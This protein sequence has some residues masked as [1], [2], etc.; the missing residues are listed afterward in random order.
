MTS[1]IPQSIQTTSGGKQSSQV[2]LTYFSSRVPTQYDING[3]NVGQRWIILGDDLTATITGA[4]QAN[5]CVITAIN[6]FSVGQLVTISSVA[7][8][9]ELNGN[10]YQILSADGNSFVIDVDSSS[11]TAY[12]SGGTATVKTV[13]EYILDGFTASNG[14]VTANWIL[15]NGSSGGAA[16]SGAVDTLTG[17]NSSVVVSS[18]T[19]GNINIVGTSQRSS[20]QGATTDGGGIYITGNDSTH[21]LT[22]T[23]E[24][25][26]SGNTFLGVDAGNNSITVLQAIQNVGVGERSLQD[27]TTGGYNTSV[28]FDSLTSL[29]SG[30]LNCAFGIDA[31]A[32]VTTASRNTAFGAF[33]L[34]TALGASNTAIGAETFLNLTSG[35]TNIGIGYQSGNSYTGAESSNVLIANLGTL[36]ENNT[37]HIG[38]FGTGSGQQNVTKLHGGTVTADSGDINA[39][40]AQ[41][42]G[43]VQIS[44]TNTSTTASSSARINVTTTSASNGDS[45]FLCNIT[46]VAAG[47]FEFGAQRSSGNFVI[48]GNVTNG[49]GNLMDGTTGLS[50]TSGGI[51]NYPLQPAFLV[52]LTTDATN[53]TGNGAGYSLGTGG[54]GAV[55]T[56]FDK[57]TNITTPAGVTTFTAPVAGRYYFH[58]RY[59]VNNIDAGM[60][61]GSCTIVTTPR[62]FQGG[63]INPGAC[64]DVNNQLGVFQCSAFIELSAGNTVTTQIALSGGGGDTA[65]INSDATN[66]ETYFEGWLVT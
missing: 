46:N 29:T 51:L 42:G 54:G 22:A 10:Q 65:G 66:P 1:Q 45:Y 23:Y 40:R 11:F 64:R 35:S 21:T 32:D 4:S 3:W 53:V 41:A 37:I 44:A 61:G 6:G 13:Q 18:D 52:I 9:T 56:I 20:A 59:S 30:S 57:G 39:S 28:G 63:L 27:L 25:F 17:N 58:V 34:S 16:G 60:T 31:L 26:G 15:I 47:I 48:Q 12:T 62:T 36:G 7:G 19:N 43:L 33:S 55:T 2:F 50:M 24:S 49:T 5:P 14:I 8:M 38:T